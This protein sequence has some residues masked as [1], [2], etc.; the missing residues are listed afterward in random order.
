MLSML[1]HMLKSQQCNELLRIAFIS[2][3]VNYAPIQNIR[4]IELY[5]D[6]RCASRHLCIGYVTITILMAKRFDK[7]YDEST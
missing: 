6:H 4:K 7:V 1:L 2:Y 5:I 3:H